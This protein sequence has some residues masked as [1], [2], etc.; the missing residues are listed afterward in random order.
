M[1]LMGGRMRPSD[2]NE[3]HE[4]GDRVC[5]CIYKFDSL[6]GQ[7]LNKLMCP[8]FKLAMFE[9]KTI[10]VRTQYIRLRDNYH[11]ARTQP[12]LRTANHI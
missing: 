4:D 2:G 12:T 8:R 9:E 1:A 7:A 3:S 10:F 11:P 5:S 6:L